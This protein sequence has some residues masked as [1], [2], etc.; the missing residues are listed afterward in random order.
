VVA[1]GVET[2]EVADHLKAVG[3]DILQGYHLAR[4]MPEAGF[5]EF[6]RRPRPT[7]AMPKMAVRVPTVAEEP[8][9][10]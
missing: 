7:A 4:P 8:S 3:I 5:L 2:Q 10:L 9:P 6:V 1:E